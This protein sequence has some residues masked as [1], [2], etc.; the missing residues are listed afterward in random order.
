MCRDARLSLSSALIGVTSWA[1]SPIGHRQ[2]YGHEQVQ[3]EHGPTDR[4]A[5][6]T[7]DHEWFEFCGV[8]IERILAGKDEQVTAH[9][10]QDE[11]NQSQTGQTDSKLTADGRIQGADQEGHQQGP[12]FV[13]DS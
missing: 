2:L 4:L 8:A 13:R 7:V 10:N 11:S 6:P 9:V 5:Q 3:C 12:L 1:S